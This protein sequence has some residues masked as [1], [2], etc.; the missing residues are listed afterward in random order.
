MNPQ[1]H[2]PALR[3]AAGNAEERATQI[4]HIKERL[5]RLVGNAHHIAAELVVITQEIEPLTASKDAL[6]PA[7]S[8]R[9]DKTNKSATRH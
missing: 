3:T 7:P 4:Q 2:P 6:N 9:A 8:N 5:D 1:L